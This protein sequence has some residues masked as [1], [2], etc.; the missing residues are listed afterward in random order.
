LIESKNTNIEETA[1]FLNG[2]SVIEYNRIILRAITVK[3]LLVLGF[4]K[5]Q[6]TTPKIIGKII[7]QVPI[8][9]ISDN[10]CRKSVWA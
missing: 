5:I 1:I 8:N 9:P 2:K 6:L 3:L 4:V 7:K 10:V